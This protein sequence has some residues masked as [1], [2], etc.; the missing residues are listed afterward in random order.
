MDD[1]GFRRD[2]NATTRE[3]MNSSEQ[4]T[5]FT[6]PRHGLYRRLVAEVPMCP[7]IHRHMT[8][9]HRVYDCLGRPLAQMKGSTVGGRLVDR[10][11]DIAINR[12]EPLR[13]HGSTLMVVLSIS[14]SWLRKASY[15]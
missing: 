8:L 1:T 7:A 13:Y 12:T 15:G 3:A 10:C 5:D 4:G 11:D 6:R 14:P 9:G 2:T